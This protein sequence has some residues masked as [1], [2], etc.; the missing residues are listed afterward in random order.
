MSDVKVTVSG[1]VGSGK[2]AIYFE[3]MVALKAI[4]VEVLH[5]APA[6]VQSEINM[7]FGD[8][9]GALE[10]YK[11]RVTMAEVIERTTND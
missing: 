5:A 11:P 8:T 9:H 7:G 3:I 4:G 2:S 10:L 1:P 6:A